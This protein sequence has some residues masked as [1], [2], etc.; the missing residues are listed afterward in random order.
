MA[1]YKYTNVTGK[2]TTLL[3]KLRETGVPSKAT[4]KWLESIGFKSTNDRSLRQILIAIGFIDREG[5]PTDRWLQYRG[6]E[7]R[8]VLG[9]AIRETYSELFETYPDACQRSTAELEAFFSTKTTGGKK[10]VSAI[11]TT[12]K[13]LCNLADFS[14]ATLPNGEAVQESSRGDGAYSGQPAASIQFTDPTT[15]LTRTNRSGGLS[16][17]IDIQIHISPDSTSSQID[18]IFASMSKHLYKL[19]DA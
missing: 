18:Q 13:T 2:L 5:K 16:L 10:V 9:S 6:A 1:D 19:D 14:S 17:H 15:L 11:V 7:H 12:F 8:A 3:H 4:T